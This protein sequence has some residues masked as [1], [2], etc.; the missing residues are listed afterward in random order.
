METIADRIMILVAEKENGNKRKFAIKV[1]INPSYVSQLDKDRTM[2]PSPRVIDKI[3]TT[4]GANRQWLETGDGE[5]FPPKS[6]GDQMGELAAA[7]AKNNV[8]VIREIFR[9]LPEKF[10]DAEILML[11][12]IYKN[13]EG[14]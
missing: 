6:L 13:H 5:P 12:Q 11:Y 1:E 10:A 8:A 4:Y 3:A 2:K 14:K 7:A 9:E